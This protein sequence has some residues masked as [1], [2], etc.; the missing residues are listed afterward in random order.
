MYQYKAKV[1]RVLDGDTCDVIIDLGFD[2]SISQRL[3][4]FGIDCPESRTR[5]P[6]EKKK[7]L[8]AKE[9]TTNAIA[10]KEVIVE[11]NEKG[12]F[13]RYLATIFYDGN[14]LNKELVD[15]KLATVYFGGKR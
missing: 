14:N 11:T 15:K 10:G 4:F 1:L 7:G 13:G 6:I 9:Y 8:L 2:V 5:N 3:R 12:K